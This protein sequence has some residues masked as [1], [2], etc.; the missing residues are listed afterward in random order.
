MAQSGIDL[1]TGVHPFGSYQLSDVDSVDLGNGKLSIDIPLISYPQRG[2]K[3][4]LNFVLHYHNSGQVL[5]GMTGC[6]PSAFGGDCIVFPWDSG[7]TIIE[8]SRPWAN[9]GCSQD[10]STLVYMCS[11]TV[12]LPDGMTV[13]MAAINSS[14]FRSLDGTNLRLDMPPGFP[15]N[16]GGPTPNMGYTLIEPTGIRHTATAPSGYPIVSEDTN[17]N[18]IIFSGNWT[19]TLNRV[20]PGLPSFPVPFPSPFPSGVSGS[21]TDYAGCPTGPLP[22]SGAVVWSPPGL[23]GG[24]YSVKFCFA[25]ISETMPQDQYDFNYYYLTTATQVQGIVLPNGTRWVFQYATDGSGNISQITLPSGGSISYTWVNPLYPNQYP[26]YVEFPD[27]VATRTL[28]SNDSR[29][30]ATWQYHYTRVINHDFPVVTRVTDPIGNDTVHTFG[31]LGAFGVFYNEVKTDFYQGS[32]VLAKTTQKD[33]KTVLAKNRAG[34]GIGQTIVPIR[35]TTIWPNGTQSKVEYDYDNGFTTQDSMYDSNGNWTGACSNCGGGL[36]GEVIAKREYNLGGSAPGALMRT[37][38]TPHLALSNQTYYNNNLFHLLS[39]KVI[40]D[41]GGTTVES[42]TYNYDEANTLVSSGIIAQHDGTPP[43]GSARGNLSSISRWLNTTGGSIVSQNKSFDTGEPYQSIDALGHAV[44]RSYDSAYLG[45][46]LTKMCD[47]LS[48]CVS[49][50]YD[51]N[52]G[53][54]I[55]FTDINASFQASG[56]TAGDAAFTTNYSYDSMFRLTQVSL[57]PDPTNG[58]IQ[59]HT[60]L[61]YSLPNIFPATVVQSQSIIAASDDISTTTYDGLGRATKVEHATPNGNATV[62]TIYDGLNRIKSKS[63]PYYSTS[64]ATYGVTT[65]NYDALG[66][67]LTVTRQDGSIVQAQYADP[68]VTTITDESG[69]QRRNVNDALGRIVEVDEPPSTPLLANYHATMQQDGNFVLYNSASTALWYTNTAGTNANSVFMQDDGNLVLYIFKWQAGVYAAPSP[70]PFTPQSCKISSYLIAGQRINPNQCIVSPHGQYMLYMAPYGNLYIYDIAHGVGTWGTNTNSSGAY[71]TLQTDGNFVVYATNGVA[72]W[73]S[74]TSGTFAERLDMEDDGRIIIYRSAWNSGTSDG[75]YNGTVIAHPGCDIGIGTGSTGVLGSGQCFVSPNGR[76]ELLMQNDGNMVIYDRSV[77]PNLAIWSSQTTL[78]PVDPS[79][80]MRTLYTYDTLGNFICVEQHGNA[81]TGTGCPGTP[82]GPTDPPIQ[83][84]PNNAWRRRLFAYDSLSRLRWASNPESGVITSSYDAD[85]YLLQKTSPLPNQ[86]GSATQTI[87]YC[88]DSLHR[89][90]G[91]A[92]S[93]Q[94]C[95][96]GQLPTGAAVVSYTYDSG[97]N[98]KGHLTSLI[99]QAGTATYAY[100]V[101][102]RLATETR[103]IAGVSKSTSYQYNLDGSVKAITYPST[104]VVTYTPD[105]AGRLVSAVDGNGINYVASVTYNA[106]GSLK[107]LLN[108][109]T[110]TL[111]QNFQYTPRLQLCRITTLTSGT[112][113]TSCTDSQHVGNVMDRGYDFHLNSGDNGNV[114]AITNYRDASRSQAFT[115]DPLNRIASG[116]SAANTGTYSWGESYSIDAWGNL[117]ISP[118]SGKDHGGNFSHSGNAQNRATGLAYDAAG[119]LMS[120]LSATYIYDQENRLSSTAGTSYTYDGNGERV[121]KSNTSTGAALKRYWSMDGNTL[122]EGDGMGNLTA[123]YVYFGGKRVAR[124]DLSAN[125]V[126]YYLSDHLGS[127]SIVANTAGAIEEE[128]DYSPFGTE[129]IVA[130]PGVNE[131]KFTGKRRDTESQLDY[132][133]ARSYGSVMGRFM[134][135]DPLG[136]ASGNLANP[137]SM[138]IYGYVLNNPMINTDPDGRECAWDDGSYD[139]NDDMGTGSAD[140]CAA[141]GGTWI[142]HDVFQNSQ[143]YRGDWSGDAN[144]TLSG[145]VAA[146]QSCSDAV[147]G[148]QGASLLIANAFTSS[149][150]NNM[151]AYVLASAAWESG[152]GGIG[153]HMIESSG[154]LGDG[155]FAKYDGRLGNNHPGDGATYKGRGYVQITGKTNYQHWSNELGVDLVQHP[156]LAATPDIAAQIAIEGLDKGAFTGVSLYNYVNPGQTDFVH[157]RQ[158]INGMDAANEIAA[159]AQKYAASLAGCR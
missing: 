74:G 75:Q 107:G 56:N 152:P 51:L 72:L 83:P 110:P 128:S 53:L 70:G 71:A 109:S 138:N 46:Y 125:T 4:G 96:N 36:F 123:E 98:A 13:P 149:F 40:T 79:V 146:I 120:Y 137:Q 117:Q 90:T 102:G 104:R 126:H 50:T 57:P 44:T 130:G 84:D 5:G 142:G 26:E 101:L 30:N 100:D 141:Q 88:Y 145:L 89:V 64:D 27:A 1:I 111:N 73:N 66:R 59:P 93:S 115:Y 157:A 24:S 112:L 78:S 2:G 48:H 17:G 155:Y 45:G 82:P 159:S 127:T 87:S 92:Y 49:A 99:D 129:T 65:T 119:N 108:G 63:N 62:D 105:S 81:P 121:M 28:N 144:S 143:F 131:L 35:D 8:K 34:G 150:T 31:A 52:S 148:G 60:G 132:F 91:K 156:A 33:Y 6:I 3:L 20:I 118:M 61:T 12:S 25:T 134:T 94:N 54:M 37:T 41:A 154:R 97:A 114:F 85:G 113:P 10:R 136:I 158:T 55:S 11:A 147:G 153:A 139:S 124:I 67:V 22:T 14:S 9:P 103:P 76:F 140:K 116:S 68:G 23:N 21:T 122:S 18:Q 151:T 19:D 39:G 47:A 133:G 15:T 16:R 106:D 80:A 58:S 32:S 69:H 95:T 77:T 43:A 42:T 86:T 7:F 29:P 38:S 135:P